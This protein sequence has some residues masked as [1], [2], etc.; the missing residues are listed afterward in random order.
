LV[1]VFAN[2]YV[3]IAYFLKN[4]FAEV[5]VRII[6]ILITA[7]IILFSPDNFFR[8]LLLPEL[9]IKYT[10]D[11]PYGNITKGDYRRESST[12][13]NQRLL[14][15][16]HDA[17]ERE[18]NIHY[19]MVQSNNPE[20]VILISGS[21]KSHVPEILKY[22]V[23]RII[24]IERDPALVKIENYQNDSLPDNLTI[25]NKDAFRYIK[26]MKEHVDVVLLLVPPSSTLL[27]N[28]FYTTEFFKEIKGKLN[29]GGIF[30]CS[31][32]PGDNYLNKESLNLYSSIFNSL[33]GVFKNV[34]PVS[35]NKLYFIGSDDELSSEVCRLVNIRKISNIYVGS[36]YLADDL[37]GQKSREISA[38]MDRNVKQ[39][40]AAFPVASYQYQ[41]YNFSKN[42]NEKTAVIGL[43]ILLFVLP[44][45]AVKRRNIIMYF[46]AAALS[47]F[48]I[49][50]LLTL[51]ITIGNMYQL[52]GLIIGGLMAGL[53]TGATIDIIILKNISARQKCILLSIF[54]LIV[55]L[56]YKLI[57]ELNNTIPVVIMLIILAFIPALI[58]GN[59]FRT[60]TTYSD[61]NKE[62]SL[63]YSADLSGSALGFILISGF[64]VPAL[65][66]EVSIYLLSCLIFAGILFGTV[67]NKK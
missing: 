1:I 18:E 61:V 11:T 46:S 58:T 48:E 45:G 12:Y 51:Q 6:I 52:T 57:L 21:L 38:L 30:M 42:L 24:Y 54:Y 22:P 23:N 27:L 50:A 28:R 41:S 33:S 3:I 34:M 39:N 59:I 49:I 67:G 37:I 26:N 4:R 2:G 36:D 13:Y 10:E 16:N 14:T 20:K 56:S 44:L 47:G 15:Y 8:G 64:T 19:A 31:P 60:L 66:I 43:M 7:V 32:G 55:G 5:S 9:K 17:T 62:V 53:A 63:T 40:K 29:P 65:G 25:V 35:G